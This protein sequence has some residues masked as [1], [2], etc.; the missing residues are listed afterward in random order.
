MTV[1]GFVAAMAAG[2]LVAW[3]AWIVVINGVDPERAG[4][5]GMVS[6]YLS[7]LMALV[8]SWTLV[9]FSLRV[10]RDPHPVLAREAATSFRHAGLLTA[11]CMASLAL[12]AQAMLS[13]GLLMVLVG[14]VCA[15]EAGLLWAS[16]TG[17]R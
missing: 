9:E 11:L 1:R 15:L 17:R 8:G 7:L 3:G 14:V 13:F 12:S 6:F 4:V 2:T 10:W 16:Q 5:S